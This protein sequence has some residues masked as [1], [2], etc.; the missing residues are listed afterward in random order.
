MKLY[1]VVQFIVSNKN[2]VGKIV[3]CVAGGL[4]SVAAHADP[5]VLP[6]LRNAPVTN[7]FVPV[8][9]DDNDNVE[10]ILHGHFSSSCYKIGT[11]VGFVDEETKVITVGARSLSYVGNDCIPMKVPFTQTV[12]L[13]QLKAGSYQVQ[14]GTGTEAMSRTLVVA[15]A[16]T[17]TADDSLYAPLEN[18][19]I[20]PVAGRPGTFNVTVSGVFPK[21]DA[22]CMGFSQ[23]KVLPFEDVLVVLPLASFERDLTKCPETN[24]FFSRKFSVSQEVTVELKGDVLIH[25]RV[26]NGQS[27][28]RVVDIDE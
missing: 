9:F 15:E 27:L 8:G 2:L 1:S 17:S 3:C 26:L 19:D 4:L 13:G 23:L 16:K 10:V 6:V 7:I 18:V 11:A 28:N 20:T 14:L 12:K 22:G 21:S 24:T 5:V 25:V